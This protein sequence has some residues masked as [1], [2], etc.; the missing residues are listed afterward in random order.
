MYE[1]LKVVGLSH[2]SSPIAIR[3]S[4][5]FS[6]NESRNFLDRMREIL[7]VE[8][9]LILSTCNRTEIYYTSDLDLSNAILNL[10]KIEKGIDHGIDSYFWN[11]ENLPALR[12]LFRVAL[13]L[14]AK[15]LGDIQISNQ[16]KKAY[17]CSADQHL[18]GPFFHRLMH[19]IFYANKRVVQETVFRDGAAS[20]SY[21]CVGLVQQFIQNFSDPK[22][23]VL[24]LGEIGRD[25]ADN[26]EEMNASITLSNR[27]ALTTHAL[28]KQYGYEVLPFEELLKNI[29]KFDVII[30][31]VQVPKPIIMKDHIP[32]QLLSQKLFVDLAVPRSMDSELDTIDGIILYN[33]DQIEEQTS[34]IIERRRAAI[35]EVEL[36]L[37]ETIEELKNWSLEMEVSPTIKK[38]KKALEEIRKEEIARYVGKVTEVEQDLID[39]VTKSIVQKVIKLPVLQ[40]KAACKRGEAETLVEVLNDLFNLEKDELT[41]KK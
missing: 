32:E 22:I 10:L 41:P 27:N 28:A 2:D 3:E 25:V 26:M 15:V 40:L 11:K 14:E 4:V 19:T 1:S 17:Q 12:H 30:S 31:S 38:L 21:A 34:G 8:E 5:A 23:L 13:G 33:V 20:V 24:G 29:A 36:I 37:D 16:V 6:E 39:K 18:S 9:A 7:G 35:T